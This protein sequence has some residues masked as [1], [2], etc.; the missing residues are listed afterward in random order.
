MAVRRLVLLAPLLALLTLTA[1]CA[2]VV[3]ASP[4]P[5]ASASPSPTAACPEQEGVDLPE[6]CAGYD[7]DAA[8]ALND[9]YRQRLEL[10]ADAQAENERLIA[11]VTAALE[12]LRTA[13][14]G[15]TE[16]GVRAAL[17]DAGATAIQTRTGAGDV[18][19]GAAGPAGGCVYG[20]L[21]AERVTVEVGGIIMDGGCLPAQ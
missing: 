17:A 5:S 21:E 15:F 1:G 16:E 9:L 12:A 6:G 10:S 20:A 11:P 2:T 7:P 8:M 4:S 14:G 18:L 19:F 3:G 13:D